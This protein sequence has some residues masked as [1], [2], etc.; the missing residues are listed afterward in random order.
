[1]EGIIFQ[2]LQELG[3]NYVMIFK[4][5]QM[6]SLCVLSVDLRLLDINLKRQSHT[7]YFNTNKH[8]YPNGGV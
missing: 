3:L 8:K 1:M 2:L 7:Q 4:L 5:F 6:P